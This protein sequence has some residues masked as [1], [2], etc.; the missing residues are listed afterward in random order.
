MRKRRMRPGR[1]L[2]IATAVVV[3]AGFGITAHQALQHAGDAAGGG[4]GAATQT[5]LRAPKVDTPDGFA[6]DYFRNWQGW[7][8][9]ERTNFKVGPFVGQSPTRAEASSAG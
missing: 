2:T 7:L 8:Q 6:L 3:L 4:N 5:A 9:Q 1:F